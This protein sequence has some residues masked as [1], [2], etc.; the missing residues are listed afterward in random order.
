MLQNNSSF[1]NGVQIFWDSTSIG[2]A[3][4][5]ARKYYYKMICGYRPKQESVHLL[6]GQHY[7]TAIEHYFKYRA[8][9]KDFE[10][11]VLT[12]VKETMLATWDYEANAPVE[13]VHKSKTRFT[14]I[15]SIIW[16]LDEFGEEAEHGIKTH[17]LADGK[18][19]VELSFQ[20][21]MESDL[22]LCGH[23]DRVCSLNS[24]LYVMDQ[25]TT[26][27]TIS[28]YFFDQFKP[29][30]Q[31]S[32][33]SLAGKVLLESP[34]KG[35]IIDGAQIAVGFT[36]FE[37]GFTYRTQEELDEWWDSAHH[38]I[39]LAQHFSEQ[40]ESKEERVFPMNCASCGNYGGCEFRPV[41][42]AAPRARKSILK[43]DF[44]QE[45]WDPAQRR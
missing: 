5:C 9:G 32:C 17:Y 18:P 14:L 26:G 23:L 44:K 22:M 37:R 16:Y 20:L 19:A 35:V 31:M 43:T 13:L 8:A 24:D 6:F 45:I 41:C 27:Y 38:T 1:D 39:R 30:T 15:R 40:V 28:A 11:A 25:K 10:K 2:L 33:Y 42:S 21:P 34:I 12:V 36:R 3:E 4:T 29:N 7:A